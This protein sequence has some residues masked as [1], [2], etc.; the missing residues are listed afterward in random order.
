MPRQGQ[1]FDDGRQ[2]GRVREKVV[3]VGWGGVGG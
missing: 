1:L 3:G 2:R